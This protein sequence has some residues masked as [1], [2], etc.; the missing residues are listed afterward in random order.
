MEDLYKA[1]KKKLNRKEALKQVRTLKQAL[2]EK[3]NSLEHPSSLRFILQRSS[4][5]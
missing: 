2:I 1:L 5:F 4:T 3:V